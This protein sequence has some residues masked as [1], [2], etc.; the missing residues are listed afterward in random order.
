MSRP[1]PAAN[2]PVA[3][4]GARPRPDDT[5]VQDQD[6]VPLFGSWRA[7]HTAVVLCALVVMALLALFARWP[8]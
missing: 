1:A 3:P 6:R 5:S 7:I 4:A 2:D 8:F